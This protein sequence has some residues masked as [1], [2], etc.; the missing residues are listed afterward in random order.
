MA[1]EALGGG[2][3][4]DLP[5]YEL[6]G[7]DPSI[8]IFL[9]SGSLHAR[10]GIF[11]R[12]PGRNEVLLGEPFIGKGGQLIRDGLHR[13]VYGTN[14]PSLEASIEVGRTI[15]WANTVPYKPLGN[16][17]WSVAVKRRF[18][19]HVVQV[20]VQHWSGQD[21]ITCGNVAF[22]WFGLVDKTLKPK[23]KAFWQ[24]EDRYE[25]S[26]N[27]DFLGKTLRLHPLPHP[28]P[29]NA[30]WYPRFP[31]LLDQRLAQLAWSGA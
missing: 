4:T 3:T 20:L 16:K 19:P 18:A 28:S 26:L 7:R 24:Q 11:G 5:V 2:M 1:K 15:F 21:L 31:A 14:C 17:A 9:G 13:A 22:E 27:L 10:V 8:P 12:D 30:R 23:L 29:L 6:A 25:R